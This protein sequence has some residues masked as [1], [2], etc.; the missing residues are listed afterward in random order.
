VRNEEDEEGVVG[1]QYEGKLMIVMDE[2]AELVDWDDLPGDSIIARSGMRE[3]RI[4]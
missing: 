2:F 3:I 1:Y 4:S